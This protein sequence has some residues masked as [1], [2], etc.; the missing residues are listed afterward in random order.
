VDHLDGGIA[1]AEAEGAPGLGDFGRAAVPA[2]DAAD[3]GGAAD[4]ELEALA[5]SLAA[6]SRAR[7]PVSVKPQAAS[8]TAS[9]ARAIAGLASTRAAACVTGA[10][11][12]GA[13]LMA[14]ALIAA[15]MAALLPAR[16]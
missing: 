3:R 9:P 15:L 16:R 12:T 7:V 13:R 2:L 11:V 6:M 1:V 5:P 14:A 10:C 4:E 8:T